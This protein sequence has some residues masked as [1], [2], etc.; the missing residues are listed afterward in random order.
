MRKS[1]LAAAALML[2]TTAGAWARPA[3]A[4]ASP[5][6]QQPGTAAMQRH[7]RDTWEDI[8]NYSAA[9]KHQAVTKAH[10]GLKALDH[11]ID[12]AQQDLN[13]HWNDMSQDAR[14]KKQKALGHLKDDRAKL[15]TQYRELK[16][17][18]ADNWDAAKARFG[19]A[20]ES[21]RSAWH[22]LVSPNPPTDGH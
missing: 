2:A 10:E 3:N 19:A 1:I 15:E 20:W 18:S 9:Q 13:R 8:R 12:R 5:T 14:L 4:D 11:R 17:A 16:A 21:T 7:A 22:D 6:A